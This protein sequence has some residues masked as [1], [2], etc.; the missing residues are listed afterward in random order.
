MWSEYRTVTK[1][2]TVS[3]HGNHYEVDAALVGRSCELLFDPFDL[4]R[5]EVHFQGRAI[6]LAVPVAIGRHTHPQVSCE[7][8]PP[9]AAS[10]IDYLGLLADRRERDVK[11]GP[12][13]DYRDLAGTEGPA[14]VEDDG[15]DDDTNTDDG[16][17][18]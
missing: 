7:P 16:S 4:T 3:L 14:D 17:N 13:I 12:G 6:G 8:D 5:I 18:R 15:A 1:T 2:A 11:G 9:A 10:G